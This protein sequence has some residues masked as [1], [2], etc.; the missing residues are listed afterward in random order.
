M[1]ANIHYKTVEKVL[2]S[3]TFAHKMFYIHC[4]NMV[5]FVKYIFFSKLQ[6]WYS[7]ANIVY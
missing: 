3:I 1:K 2:C 4:P 5:S 7:L 6:M